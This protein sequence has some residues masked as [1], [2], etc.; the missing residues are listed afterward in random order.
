MKKFLSIFIVFTISSL[1]AQ[2]SVRQITHFNF[3]VANPVVSQSSGWDSWGCPSFL[4]FE[5]HNGDSSNIASLSYSG[6]ND[7]FEDLKYFTRDAY[8][9]KNPI[10]FYAYNR[11]AIIWETNR[12]GN[13]DIAY[14]IND[15]TSNFDSVYLAT[16]TPEDEKEI[17][18]VTN[19]PDVCDTCILTLFK[20]GTYVIIKDI[21]SSTE[22]E[23]TVFTDENGV[24]FSQ[25][26]AAFTFYYSVP[27]IAVAVKDSSGVKS[28]V[29]RIKNYNDVWGDIHT[30]D[31][32]G[33]PDNPVFANNG[34]LFCDYAVNGKSS[35]Y[36]L[37][38]EEPE[39]V[40]D[41]VI[42]DSTASCSKLNT[43]FFMIPTQKDYPLYFPYNFER[44]TDDGIFVNISDGSYVQD[45]SISVSVAD[46]QTNIGVL[47]YNSCF[48]PV[49]SVWVDSVNGYKNIF[50]MMKYV[51]QGG[52]GDNDAHVNKF[53]LHQNYPNPYNPTTT[54]E[55]SIPIVRAKNFSSQQNVQLKIYD[56][57][58]REVA[59]LVN[60]PQT[61]GNY[62][63][64]FDAGALPSGT[65]F[66]RLQVGKTSITKKMILLK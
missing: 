63:V 39:V 11:T 7:D 33:V 43:M 34:E 22:P 14:V 30:V 40:I 10:F 20:R 21:L 16:N 5:A 55:Y 2:D 12:N 3:D 28:L 57:L 23:D 58:G 13:F 25:P 51:A 45:T 35:I 48:I 6:I 61:P 59:E 46:P 17:K 56:I 38:F 31:F 64:K 65:Y 29:Y 53:I 19:A 27:L 8:I 44:R 15:N 36:H 18:L 62:S 1:F 41:T 4:I 47:D 37:A 54:I 60:Q 49:L 42:T 26:A 24:V 66:Y 32:E 52:V 9:N 50:G